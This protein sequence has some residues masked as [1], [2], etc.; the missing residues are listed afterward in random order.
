MRIFVIEDDPDI[1]AA[2][3]QRIDMGMAVNRIR[4]AYLSGRDVGREDR[5]F[6]GPPDGEAFPAWLRAL[7][8]AFSKIEHAGREWHAMVDD[9]D[10]TRY[11]RPRDYTEFEQRQRHSHR[12]AVLGMAGAPIV[13]F[14][15]GG[16]TTR[17][18]VAPLV[19]LA[20]QVGERPAL[21]PQTR[22]VHAYPDNEIGQLEGAFDE[23]YNRLEAALQ[24]ERLFTADVGHG[25][26]AVRAGQ[27]GRRRQ[28]RAEPV[29]GA[30]HL[31][32]PALARHAR[33]RAG[34]RL[35]LPHR[36]A[37]GRADAALLSTAEARML[38]RRPTAARGFD[39]C[40]RAA[41]ARPRRRPAR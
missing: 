33:F 4:N 23:T 29:A 34:A 39:S 3:L 7:P 8:P 28:P 35:P 18:F 6:H 41:A 31:S 38:K 24:R 1:L 37:R 21:P 12:V 17:R 19:R 10:G 30:A 27:R 25:V 26:R 5:F 16:A 2:H 11:L 14:V 36:P 32:A 13:A 15:L 20:A 22:L 9:R 40:P